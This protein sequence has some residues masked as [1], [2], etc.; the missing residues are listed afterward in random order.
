MAYV[1]AVLTSTL[2]FV[3]NKFLLAR[4]GPLVV[5]TWGPVMEEAVKTLPAY[6]L[7]ADVLLTHVLFGLI[8]AGYDA[9]TARH[10]WLAAVASLAGHS[11]FGAITV[12]LTAGVGVV[13]GLAAAMLAHLA[14]NRVA[15]LGGGPV[16]RR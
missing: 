11:V 8:E 15:V 4:I 13:A 1:L 3:L 12:L 14:W 6:S 9:L 5:V 2:A 16:R 7:G 10:G